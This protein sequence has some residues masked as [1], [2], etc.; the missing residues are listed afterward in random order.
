MVAG[1][2]AEVGGAFGDGVGV[3]QAVLLAL[4][5]VLAVTAGH[6]ADVEHGV[7]KVRKDLQ[8]FVGPGALLVGL[9]REE[10]VL[11]QREGGHGDL[12]GGEV[13]AE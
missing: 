13:L 2:D 11:N 12:G 8:T 3:E 10:P 6:L 4:D 1:A 7:R 5:E 9:L